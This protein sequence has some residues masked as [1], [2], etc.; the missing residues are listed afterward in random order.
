MKPSLFWC[1]SVIILHYSVRTHACSVTKS[2]L[3]LYDSMDCSLPGSYNSRQEYY[4]ILSFSSPG[5]LPDSGIEPLNSWKTLYHRTIWEVPLLRQLHRYYGSLH[6]RTTSL[7][8]AGWETQ[9]PMTILRIYRLWHH[10]S[11]KLPG[12][13]SL[14]RL[15]L[16]YFRILCI[17]SSHDTEMR[18]SRF[19]WTFSTGC[20]GLVHWHDPE[21][22]Y[23]EGGGRRV[24][25]GGFMLIYGKTNTIL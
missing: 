9:K 7:D 16:S 8:D 19:N 3:I 21:G 5:D 17:V 6:F 22:W 24:Q 18:E 15:S 13:S 14:A 10:L 20:L 23:G 2:C 11:N 25:D 4:S 12:L 1:Y